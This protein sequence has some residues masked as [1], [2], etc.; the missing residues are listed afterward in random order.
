MYLVNLNRVVDV[1]AVDVVAV[2]AV[3][4]DAVVVATAAKLQ[5]RWGT[6]VALERK[7]VMFSSSV[8]LLEQKCMISGSRGG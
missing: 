5:R 7:L 8:T 6:V 4:V 3:V 2:D 1:V